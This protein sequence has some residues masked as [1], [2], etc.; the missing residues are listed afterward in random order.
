[1]A[2]KETLKKVEHKA[3][4]VKVAPV[5]RASVAPRTST[6]DFGMDK[7]RLALS[8]C[9]T[10]DDLTEISKQML[11]A[12]SELPE[13]NNSKQIKV[14]LSSLSIHKTYQENFKLMLHA[15]GIFGLIINK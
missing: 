5:K 7:L 3:T 1:M 11:K 10:T 13:T 2:K 4:P 12:I 14:Y 6:S 15:G 9:K 8:K